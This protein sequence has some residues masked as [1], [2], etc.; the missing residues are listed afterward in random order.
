M[1]RINLIDTTNAPDHLHADIETNYAANDI[2]F[3]AKASTINSLKLIAHIP[4]VAR[5]LAPLI[6]A[7]QRN[8]AGSILP[9]KLKTLVDIKTST[10]NDC[11]Y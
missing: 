3:G 1:A 11:F 7:M 5:W 8:G 2:L 6:A 9:A 10:I 4:L